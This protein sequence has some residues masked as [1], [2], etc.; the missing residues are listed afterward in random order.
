MYV[1][2]LFLAQLTQNS[3][4]RKIQAT[5]AIWSSER[6]KD[7]PKPKKFTPKSGF[8]NMKSLAALSN[9]YFDGVWFVWCDILK[10]S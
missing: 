7:K 8:W 4:I 6:V 5:N 10:A 2:T 3:A 9:T 1:Q